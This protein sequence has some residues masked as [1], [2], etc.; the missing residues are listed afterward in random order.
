[1]LIICSPMLASPTCSSIESPLEARYIDQRS[2]YV[3]PANLQIPQD[4]TAVLVRC[5]EPPVPPYHALQVTTIHPETSLRTPQSTYEQGLGAIEVVHATFGKF[6]GFHANA[7]N[8]GLVDRNPFSHTKPAG[9]LPSI[10]PQRSDIAISQPL[11]NYRTKR[12]PF[13]SRFHREQTAKTRQIG[14]CIRC[15]LLRI[16]VSAFGCHCQG[17]Y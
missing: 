9:D 10:P 7:M 12:G 3:Y 14:S 8:N 11:R 2:P 4:G 13:R 1:M 6:D 15:R 16:R 5:P 17:V